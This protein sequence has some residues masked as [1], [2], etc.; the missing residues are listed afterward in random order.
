MAATAQMLVYLPD[1]SKGDVVREYARYL[2]GLLGGQICYEPAMSKEGAGLIRLSAANCD[3]IVFGEPKQSWFETLLTGQPCG[4]VIAQASTSFLLARQPRWPIRSILL[5]LRIGKTDEAAVD[6]L[7]R[8]AQPCE[9][10]VTILPLV[11]SL[12]AMYR[13]GN[14]VQA[15]LDVLLSPNTP[16]GRHLRHI[17]EQLK[18]WQIEGD[19]HLRQGEPDWQIRDEVAEGNFDL[20]LIGAEPHGRLYRFLLGE[21]V[22]PLL[23]WVDRPLLIAQPPHLGVEKGNGQFT[24]H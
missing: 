11:P 10:A 22:G 4:Q 2:R 19:L 1:S 5:I 13:M 18:K 12:P 16:S 7:S 15:G 21:L 9:T 6:W 20:I 8:L 14:R 23:C 3:L 24:A 17:A